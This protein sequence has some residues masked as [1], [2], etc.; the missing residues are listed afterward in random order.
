ME[1]MTTRCEARV[2][3]IVRSRK[4]VQYDERLRARKH[5]ADQSEL[6]EQMIIQGLKGRPTYQHSPRRSLVNNPSRLRPPIPRRAL[7][8]QSR[9]PLDGA[10]RPPDL[11]PPQTNL[12][13]L[14]CSTRDL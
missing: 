5:R 2:L 1:T 6:Q 12:W 8:L 4:R 7:V 10:S 9:I 3:S 11:L 13:H 14:A